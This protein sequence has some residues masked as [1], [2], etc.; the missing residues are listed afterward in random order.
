MHK[1]FELHTPTATTSARI[2]HA[3]AADIISGELPPGSKLD[4]VGLS[5]RFG[6][7][8]TPVREALKDLLAK[9]L[10][11]PAKRGVVVA[12][13]GIEELTD[14]LEA[15]CEIEALCARLASQKMSALEKEHLKMLC[16]QGNAVIGTEKLADYFDLNDKFHM[17]IAKGTHNETL[18]STVR[19]WR[20]RLAPFRR[21]QPGEM[22]ERL[23]QSIKEHQVIVGAISMGDGEA[24]YV[25]ARTHNARLSLGTLLQVSN[26]SVDKEY[27]EVSPSKAPEK[28]MDPADAVS[29]VPSRRLL[30]KTKAKRRT[31]DW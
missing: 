9:R 28:E 8:R 17:L 6:V 22:S 18:E 25:A 10:V 2:S 24:A 15:D 4:E 26:L 12:R 29:V 14:M 5:Q 21:A 31:S 19:L 23:L 30:L 1:I 11:E 7:S 20:N 16:E 13:I 3:L 27:V